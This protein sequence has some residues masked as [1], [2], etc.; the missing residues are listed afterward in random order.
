MKDDNQLVISNGKTTVEVKTPVIETRKINM[1]SVYVD[2]NIIAVNDTRC[3][4]YEDIRT[5]GGYRFNYAY[6]RSIDLIFNA[7][8]VEKLKSYG[9]LTLYRVTLRDKDKMMVNLL[10]LTAS[11]KS[12]KLIYGFDDK[13]LT[14]IEDSLDQNNTV[15]KHEL[16]TTTE[17]RDHCI[18]SNWQPKL[19]IMDNLVGKEGGKI[20]GGGL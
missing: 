4:V 9:N 16:A 12:L 10:A 3:I 1:S 6:K 13:A 5:A 2:Q 8:R 20:K 7:Y 18:K 17:R 14:A 19:L 15:I 11:K